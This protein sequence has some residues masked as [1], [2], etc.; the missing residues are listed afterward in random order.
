MKKEKKN[1]KEGRERKRKRKEASNISERESNHQSGTELNQ[2]GRC[3]RETRKKGL[4]G[5]SRRRWPAVR[6]DTCRVPREPR[7]QADGRKYR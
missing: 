1:Q 4:E 6:S 7:M 2:R 3:E 5:V